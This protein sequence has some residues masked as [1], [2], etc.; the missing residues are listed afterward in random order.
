MRK[1]K[2]WNPTPSTARLGWEVLQPPLRLHCLLE[3]EDP[4]AQK[5]VRCA[6]RSLAYALANDTKV[7]MG[8]GRWDDGTPKNQ[9]LEPEIKKHPS[10]G[11]KKKILEILNVF[12]F[13]GSIL[14]FGEVESIHH[15]SQQSRT[16]FGYVS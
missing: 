11:R 1:G 13:I 9:Q 7:A 2:S 15:S 6:V 3:A 10:F 14:K 16:R 5:G 8:D 12:R 4:V